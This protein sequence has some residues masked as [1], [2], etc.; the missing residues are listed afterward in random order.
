MEEQNPFT[1]H[2][3]QLPMTGEQRKLLE[4]EHLLREILKEI[5]AL[6]ASIT[7]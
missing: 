7:K 2:A 5:A 3:P 1:P 6:R 4:L